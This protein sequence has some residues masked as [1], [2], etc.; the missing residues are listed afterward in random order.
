MTSFNDNKAG[1]SGLDKEKIQKIISENTSANYEQ[2][3]Q[4]QK[5]RIQHKINQNNAL[6]ATFTD[7]QL[8]Q[9]EMEMDIY[10]EDLE[11]FRTA[12]RTKI[13]VDMDAFYAAV[14]MLEAPELRDVP[15][16]VG[17]SDMLSTSNYP[18]RKFGVRAGM[19]G[20]IGK[21]LCPRLKIVP[22]NFHKYKAKSKEAQ[23]VFLEYDPNLRMGSLDEAYMDFTDYLKQRTE[24]ATRKRIR[25][26]GDCVCVL[27]LMK[28]DEEVDASSIVTEVTCEKCKKKRVSV[29]DSVTFGCEV[30]DV[31][32][33]M[34]F[35]VEQ[36]TG[37]TCSAG[38]AMNWRLAKIGSDMNKPNGQFC[39]SKDKNG[40][41]N[42]MK[43]L[44]IRKVPGI[45]GVSEAVLKGLGIEKCGDLYK[46]RAQIRLLFTENS[47]SWYLRVALGIDGDFTESN[48]D[49]S[50]KSISVE[51]TFSPSSNIG[52]LLGTVEELCEELITS[53]PKK[54]IVGGRCATLKVKFAS[55]DVITRAIS[56][57]YVVKTAEQLFTIL[58]V[59]L[60]KEC[61]EKKGVRLLGVKL[62]KL[63]F[64]G[65]PKASESTTQ[66]SLNDFFK[67]AEICEGFKHD[68]ETVKLEDENDGVQVIENEQ[69]T[70][71]G[72]FGQ[73]PICGAQLHTDDILAVNRHIDRCLAVCPVVLSGQDAQKDRKRK[74]STG[75]RAAGSSKKAPKIPN[76]AKN[77]D[78]DVEV[79][80][81]DAG[82]SAI[83]AG[84]CPIC[85]KALPVG[86]G[87]AVNQHIDECLNKPV[88]K[89][90]QDNEEPRNGA[91]D[92]AKPKPTKAEMMTIDYQLRKLFER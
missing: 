64:T 38:I 17:G 59:V 68:A 1:M 37:L 23:S 29:E 85:E 5:E 62:S 81:E 9:A 71:K 61:D 90:L 70:S 22:P 13:H 24:P 76:E 75:E 56:V 16:A 57:D 87:R 20:F 91:G 82:P 44:P 73:C 58:K 7:E 2:H 49:A 69:G 33:E 26:K 32:S 63:Q 65:D 92:Q 67:K 74:N 35:R 51:R 19:P 4:K 60:T 18:A 11:M 36:K 78:P 47:W 30:E 28:N 79:I 80:E 43:D 52:Q 55:F 89:K 77:K 88:L 21:K 34:R 3:S 14:E 40:I 66:R 27:P 46:K 83:S 53:L 72:S 25:Y 54:E 31:V 15:M 10:A 12:D 42:F 6:L 8:T 39:V 45:G 86:N 41:I 50:R 84:A 48:D